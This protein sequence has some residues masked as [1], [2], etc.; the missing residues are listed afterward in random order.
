[1]NSQGLVENGAKVYMVDLESKA[2][3]TSAQE[4]SQLA[5]VQGTSVHQ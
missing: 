2:F 1:M 5:Q 3:A 4:L